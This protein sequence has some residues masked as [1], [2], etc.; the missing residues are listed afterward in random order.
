MLTMGALFTDF[1]HAAAA[2]EA[3]AGFT[4][5]ACAFLREH[6]APGVAGLDDA[7]LT[8]LVQTFSQEATTIGATGT[9]HQLRYMVAAVIWGHGFASDPQYAAALARANWPRELPAPPQRIDSA[10]TALGPE[11]D[12]FERATGSDRADR[13]RILAALTDIAN[14][15]WRYEDSALL[16]RAVAHVWPAR[17]RHLGEAELPAITHAILYNLPDAE[18]ERGEVAL[19]TMLAFAFGHG[20]CHDPALPWVAG[21]LRADS[22]LRN[23]A[24]LD[25]LSQHYADAISAFL[26]FQDRTG[27]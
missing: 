24:L 16:L 11:I 14:H 15:D 13:A 27:S 3:S 26:S 5:R 1:S 12:L 19:L 4:R 9:A 22:G 23:A 21:A 2:E 18:F 7:G 17:A 25:G 20:L 10:L 8:Q 6:L